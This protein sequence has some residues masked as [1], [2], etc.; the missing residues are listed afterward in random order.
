MIIIKSIINNKNKYKLFFCDIYGLIDFFKINEKII[1]NFEIILKAHRQN[2]IDCKYIKIFNEDIMIHH[3][4]KLTI[5]YQFIYNQKNFEIITMA[6]IGID[7]IKKYGEFSMVHTNHIYRGQKFCQ[8]N[9]NL[10][11]NNILSFKNNNQIKKFSLYV[12][13][14][15]IPAIKCY[16]SCGF[17]IKS[18]EKEYFLMEK[19]IK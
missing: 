7:N 14:T 10:F 13:Q 16:E 2:D 18:K 6:R 11:M 9:I 19:I 1:N 4:Y 15:N 12:R 5:Y 3:M 8:K 17:E